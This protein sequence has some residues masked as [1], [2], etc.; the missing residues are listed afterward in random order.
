M[1]PAV[2]ALTAANDL[3]ARDVMRTTGSPT[4]AKS[5]PGCNPL[6]M[7]LSTPDEV[8]DRD[9]I[10][11]RT[12]VNDELRQDDTS[13]G[14]IFSVP[15]LVARLSHYAAL[16]PGDVVLTGT[17]G[18]HRPGPPLLP[19]PGRSR[20]ASRSSPYCLSMTSVV[21]PVDDGRHH[22]RDGALHA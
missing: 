19:R 22:V 4:L 17:P 16:E 20:P 21:A 12:W 5:F 9:R 6:G 7:S 13:A 11:V 10:R 8:V 3:S 1:W 2:A 15:D 18:R 14:L